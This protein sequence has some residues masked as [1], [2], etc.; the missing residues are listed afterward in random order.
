[1]TDKK[2]DYNAL[3]QAIDTSWGRSS[4][5]Q[6]SSF[7]VKFTLQG[8]RM[9]ASYAAIVNFSTEKD[10]ILTKRSYANESVSVIAEVLKNVKTNYKE[11]AG[12]TLKTKEVLSNDSVE[13]IG[14]AVHNPKRTAYYRRKTVYD[15]A[16]CHQIKFSIESNRSKKY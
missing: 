15:I 3:G 11:L 16:L 5:P 12:Q 8:N 4:T 2:I 9:I 7:S 10:M 13:I 6:A 1:M 14:F